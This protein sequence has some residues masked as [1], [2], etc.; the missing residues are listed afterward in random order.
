MD[1]AEA[2]LR[3]QLTPWNEGYRT[4]HAVLDAQHAAMLQL[5]DELAAQC[6]AGD[7][8]A[9]AFEATVERLKALA[10]EHFAAEAALLPEGTDLDELQDERSEFG[11]LAAEVATTGHFDRVERQRFLALWCLGHIAGWAPRLRAMAP[12]G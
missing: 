2:A 1:T 12:R 7:D 11:Y 3:P 4:G 8:A 9:R 6:G 10:N 5:C